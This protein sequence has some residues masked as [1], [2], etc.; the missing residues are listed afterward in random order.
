MAQ[1][2]VR[3]TVESA[4]ATTATVET[5]RPETPMT[6]R[7]SGGSLASS[8]GSSAS[9]VRGSLNERTSARSDSSILL[10]VP[11]L[12]LRLWLAAREGRAEDVRAALEEGA[13]VDW[14]LPEKHP[15]ALT[16]KNRKVRSQPLHAA[17]LFEGTG[18]CPSRGW[19]QA[20]EAVRI[21]LEARAVATATAKVSADIH[22]RCLQAIH[23][24]AAV[25][26]T[27]TIRLLVE[28]DADP[29]APATSD[30][31]AHYL[32]I[33]DAV[34]FDRINSV[35]C[36][37][38]VKASVG[39]SNV[40]GETGLH[41]AAKLGYVDLA[42]MLLQRVGCHLLLKHR[43]KDGSTPFDLAVENGQFPPRDLV[44]F[45]QHLRQEEHAHAFIK[46]ARKCPPAAAALLRSTA[47][48]DDE[49]G[50]QVDEE[51]RSSLQAAARKGT[52]TTRDFASLI[53]HAPEAAMDLVDILTEVPEMRDKQHHPLPVRARLPPCHPC[54]VSCAYEPDDVWEWSPSSKENRGGQPWHHDFA[55][56]D[57]QRGS[58]VRIRVLRLPGVIEAEVLRSLA[59]TNELRL[60]T[61]L[62]VHALLT[63]AW[64]RLKWVFVAGFVHEVLASSV[65]CIWIWWS[66]SV[67]PPSPIAR[68]LLWSCVASQG[69]VDGVSVLLATLRCWYILG[70]EALPQFLVQMWFRLVVAACT[71]TLAH[72]L[73]ERH[74]PADG[75]D[76]SAIMAANSLLHG[77]HMLYQ[78]RAFQ[79][80]GQRLLPIM[81]SVQ[82]IVGMLVIMLFLITSFLNAFWAMDRKVDGDIRIFE[83]VVYLFTGEGFLQSDA[84]RQ[85]PSSQRTMCIVLTVMACF[86][87]LAI[88]LNVFI[89][90]LSD[91]YDQEQ[92]RMACTFLKER[93]MLCSSVYLWP[94]WD[95]LQKRP[96]RLE[97][98]PGETRTSAFDSEAE[99]ELRRSSSNF[100]NIGLAVIVL[101][102]FAGAVLCLILEVGSWLGV[103]LLS[104]GLILLQVHLRCELTRDWERRYLWLCHDV[105]VEEDMFMEPEHGSTVETYGRIAVVKRYIFDQCKSVA[106]E[107]RSVQRSVD[108]CFEELSALRSEV[109]SLS[110]GQTSQ[111]APPRKRSSVMSEARSTRSDWDSTDAY[112]M[113]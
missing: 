73:C 49:R 17:A 36:L 83:V 84:L 111:R 33:H 55:P 14:E 4:A 108:E 47:R 51:W 6:L 81:K 28:S 96:Q 109:R 98:A 44:L 89:A 8:V 48:G 78:L 64:R 106:L 105:H 87:F 11:E 13:H 22:R 101:L 60:F 110:Q 46:V 88:A 3:F 41:L 112:F 1:S 38:E 77:I 68:K 59:D 92:E 52:I 94:S 19:P 24:A 15:L 93:A 70:R 75:S 58:E 27:S 32:P 61:K 54:A 65:L 104:A 79:W 107:C 31:K 26:N 99:P 18:R 25:G 57:A 45:T 95:F 100:A 40:L 34:W 91:C 80:S 85:M 72:S 35:K 82:P 56:P 2:E 30:G 39:G 66:I 62:V 97:S 12:E 9:S 113:L 5:E 71:V 7:G 20:E 37:I 74:W 63:F 16:Y 76:D 90:V 103:S 102:L 23:M 21:L 67:E 50:A 43:D 10:Q 86:L 53:Q 42:T 29:D 69:I